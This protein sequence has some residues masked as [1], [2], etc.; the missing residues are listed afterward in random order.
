MRTR[1]LAR[2][3]A[4]ADYEIIEMLLF[5]GIP[6]R[7]TKPEA[8]GLINRFGSLAAA[9]R[10]TGDELGRAG[11]P[12]A[13]ADAFGVVAAAAAHLSQ[14]APATR[15]RLSDWTALERYLDPAARARQPP[16]FAALLLDSR[17][18]LLGERR[19]AAET[20]WAVLQKELLQHAVGQY[21][22]ALILVRSAGRDMPDILP[23]DRGRY[24]GLS[25]AAGNLSV[26]LHDL[27][28]IGGGDW[29]SL[30]QVGG[31]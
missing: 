14:V 8:K 9:L 21:A 11:L 23:E 17:N 4:L 2:P 29:L 5:L 25:R 13:V 22:A 30:R 16:G 10:A 28:V 19:W 7:D 26:L 15:P 12:P 3:A 1:L 27:L 31:V 6:R 24:A 20:D 18:Q